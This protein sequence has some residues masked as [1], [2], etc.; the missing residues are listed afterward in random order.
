MFCSLC[1]TRL[2]WAD[3]VQSPS[4][5]QVSTDEQSSTP[6]Q[7]LSSSRSTAST[8]RDKPSFAY[9][10]QGFIFPVIGLILYFVLRTDTPLRARSAGHGALWGSAI[11]LVIVIVLLI[12]I[13]M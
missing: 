7:A 2:P 3:A 8:S 13:W 9:A 10:L 5:E 1:G 11:Q 4:S 6:E 12:S